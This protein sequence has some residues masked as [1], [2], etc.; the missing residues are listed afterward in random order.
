[1]T[2]RMRI[3]SVFVL[4]SSLII[5]IGL[6]A[7]LIFTRNNLVRSIEKDMSVVADTADRFLS[8]EINLQKAN[9][10]MAANYLMEASENDFHQ[11]LEAQ[12]KVY[13]GIMTLTVVAPDGVVDSAGYPLFY[14]GFIDTEY[15]RRAFMGEKI[16]STSRIY[17]EDKG[18]LFHIC[19]PME[20]NSSKAERILIATIDGMFFSDVLSGLS[21]WESGYIFIVDADGY[22]LANP[23]RNWVEERFN[24][25]EMAKIDRQYESIASVV[26]KMCR[27]ETGVGKF[28]IE[29]V[30]RF[31]AYRPIT[32]SIGGWSLGVTALRQESP[33]HDSYNG[34]LLVGVVCFFLSVAVAF[35]TSNIV[36]KP[37]KAASEMVV[38]L[39]QQD[40]ML[41]TMN[42]VAAILLQSKPDQ[43]DADLLDCMGM[44]AQ[45]ISA[46]NVRVF[47]NFTE[48][49]KLCCFRINRWPEDDESV[50]MHNIVYEE[51]VP[52]W[53]KILSE[54]KCINSRVEDLP[55]K[56]RQLLD[57]YNILSILVIPVFIHG[58]FWGWVSFDN[59][60]KERKFSAEEENILRSGTLLMVDA[61][62]RNEAERALIHAHEEAVASTQAKTHFLANMSHEMRTPLNVIIGL[63]DLTIGAGR[64]HGEDAENLGKIYSSGMTLLGIINDI[65]DLSK[66][67]SGKFDI[68]P[69]EYDL[70]NL[71]N[72][73]VTVSSVYIGSKSVEIRL[74]IDPDL[75]S[76]LVGDDLRL[77]QIFNNILSNAF[78]YTKEGYVDWT[79]SCERDGGSVWLVSTVRDTGIGIRP[80]DLK[81]LF[82]AYNQVDPKSNRRV[83]GTGL[84]L[85]LAKRLAEMMDGNI[86]VES[87]YGKGSVF[88]V[89][90]RQGFVNGATIGTEVAGKLQNFSFFEHKLDLSTKLIRVSIPYARVLVVDDVAANLDV[91]RGLMKPYDMQVDCVTN[92][93]VAVKLIREEKVRYNAIFMD[94]M[95]PDMDGIEVTRIIRQ[96]IGT[97]YAKN[98]PI[99]ALTANAIVGN[100][101]MFLR[102]GFTAYLSKPIDIVALDVAINRWVRDKDLERKLNM[103]LPKTGGTNQKSGAAQ[104]N[105][106]QWEINGLNVK[107]SIEYF[108][109]DTGSFIDVLKSYVMNT[110]PLLERIQTI[111]REDMDNY[112]V[113][114]HGIK[115]SSRSI[116]A[117]KT[118]SQA[119]A[120]E[121]AAATGDFEFVSGNNGDFVRSAESLIG[122]ISSFLENLEKENSKPVSPEPEKKVLAELLAACKS[123]DIDEVD[124]AME[125]LESYSYES[126]DDFI[127]WLREQVNQMGF[128]KIAER[129]E[130]S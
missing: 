96:E 4:M 114:V 89:R 75:P 22:I 118:G 94:H 74:H 40:K 122:N 7:G 125:K 18:L 9:V 46:D 58:A 17:P 30:E 130:N 116:G 85:S 48:N 91:A 52:E 53:F 67:E 107:K 51:E 71:I 72:D 50:P 99:I 97:K 83:E 90:L 28:N 60:K 5:L 16:I 73:T 45:C 86:A 13:K 104:G 35:V 115:S 20:M 38:K 59:S 84:G 79:V 42:D 36:E 3:L 69:V 126:G 10:A 82:S 65:L 15:T 66:I 1:M 76:T 37:Y 34:L 43:F 61:L 31:C 87:E 27:G 44:I 29:G 105:I 25:I 103:G 77:K 19:V 110:P 62:Q 57:T 26:F 101:A 92:G 93:A 24:F 64:L 111:N 78:K 117:E 55:K 68:I 119:E 100:K 127:L 63:S 102:N 21:L 108:G 8:T 120:L 11:V 14:T 124:A 49:G 98:I 6:G 12:V 23:R 129:L 70:P 109:G 39:G 106:S 2:I 32:A 80:E 128:K 112:K 113:I 41:Y 54:G 81:K 47:R 56:E 88:T 95:M 121:H 123:L 33:L